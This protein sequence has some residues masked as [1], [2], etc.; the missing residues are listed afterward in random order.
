VTLTKYNEYNE[1]LSETDPLGHATRYAYDERGNCLITAMPGGAQLQREYDVQDRCVALT[2]AVGGQWQW[3]Y[4]PAG[5]LSARTN[6]LGNTER[7]E[8]ANGLLVCLVETGKR[9]T[10]LTYDTAYNLLSPRLPEGLPSHWLCDGWGRARKSTDARGNVQW[11]EYDLLNRLLTMHE[12]DGNVRRFAYDALNNIVRTQ[13]R[14]SDVQYAYRGLGSLMR[15]IEAGTVVEF[16]HDTEEQLRAVVNEHGL[17]YR[18]EL[19]GE[20]NVITEVGFDGLTRRYQRDVSG[21]VVELELPTGLLTRYAYDSVGRIT[22]VHYGDGSREAYNY[23]PDGLLL[24]AT[25]DTLAVTFEHDVMGNLLRETQ[26]LHVVSSEADVKGHRVSL[27]SSLGAQVSYTR[28]AAGRVEQLQAGRWQ[29]RFERDAQGLELRRQLPRGVHLR[30]VRDPLGRLSEQRVSTG[31]GGSLSSRTR[32]YHWQADDRL[33][34]IADSQRGLTRFEHDA[35]GNLVATTF[36]DGQRQLRQP[37][38]VSNLFTTAER[39]ERQYGSAGQLLVAN[40]TAYAYDE[41]GNLMRKTLPTGQ[42]WAY[43]WN[44]AG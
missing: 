35:V 13:D 22:Q 43:G 8:Y 38:A 6:P 27:T 29:A 23:R 10:E 34:Q 15:R 17:A 26:G 16:W 20:G 39:R 32:T 33:T 12:P 18:F 44:A 1:V 42:Q 40:G 30:S 14:S 28:D 25:N 3:T 31:M 11:R 37:D 5:N 24:A 36:G 9:V 19:D 21:R 2:D 7:Y 41:L 4:D